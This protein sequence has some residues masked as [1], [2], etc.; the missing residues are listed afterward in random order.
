LGGAIGL[1]LGAEHPDRV[2]AVVLSGMCPQ[3][4]YAGPLEAWAGLAQLAR[5]IG[6][7]AQALGQICDQE[8][9]PADSWVREHKQGDADVVAQIFDG[10]REY[11]W[12]RRVAPGAFPLPTL[13]L[14]GEHEDPGDVAATIAEA[15]PRARRIRLD[16][17]GHV[18]G[19]IDAGRV[20][21]HVRPFLQNVAIELGSTR[22]HGAYSD[23]SDL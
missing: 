6:D 2:T 11:E 17:V 18:G 5:E 21:K 8:G 7:I 20:L 22:T 9:V 13:I 4:H 16:G 12:D 1:L 19:L 23:A 10:L 14:L 3:F 15:M